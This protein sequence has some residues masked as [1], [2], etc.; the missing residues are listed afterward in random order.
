MSVIKGQMTMFKY[1]YDFARDGGAVGDIPLTADVNAIPLSFVITDVS[2]VVDTALTTGGS[3]TLTVGNSAD[4]DGYLADIIAELS[5]VGASVHAGE[6]AGALLWDDT[7]DHAIE[8]TV[9]STA[10]AIPSISIGTA[11]LTAGKLLVYVH[12]YMPGAVPA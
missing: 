7:N 8:Y 12:G 6:V 11:A 2:V 9:P 10:A 1:T 5:G 4:R 3:P